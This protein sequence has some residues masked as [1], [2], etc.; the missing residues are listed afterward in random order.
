MR[1][2]GLAQ[3]AQH[4]GQRARISRDAVGRW[5]M[6][7]RKR[8]FQPFPPPGIRGI[9][10]IV[11]PLAIG[12]VFSLLFQS[13]SST[14]TKAG[15]WIVRVGN[16]PL[17]PVSPVHSSCAYLS[18]IASDRHL[19]KTHRLAW[20]RSPC[21]FPRQSTPSPWQVV[22]VPIRS[23]P[24]TFPCAFPQPATDITRADRDANRTRTANGW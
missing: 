6:I 15:G 10:G 17:V 20:I 22:G 7:P 11:Q 4:I 9:P 13:W 8:G 21:L 19:K 16:S 12:F 18:R 24:A 3:R 1:G 2:Q 14:T 23:S 5:A